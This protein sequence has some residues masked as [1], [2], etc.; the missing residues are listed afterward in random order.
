MKEMT[1]P[2]CRG[3]GKV[4]SGIWLDETENENLMHKFEICPI[5][6]GEGIVELG[7]NEYA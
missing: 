3:T 6:K 5:C 1:C 7:G 2:N 4:S